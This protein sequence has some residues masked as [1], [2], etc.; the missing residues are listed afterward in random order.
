M[1]KDEPDY[2]AVLGVERDAS[3]RAIKQAYRELVRRY[4]PDAAG[5]SAEARRQFERL[6]EA[7]DVLSNPDKRA[8]YDAALPP[9]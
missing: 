6:Q 7:Y 2:Y 3:L 5:D 4:H 9:R 8:R 1:K